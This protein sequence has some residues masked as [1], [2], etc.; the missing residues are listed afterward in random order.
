VTIG[1]WAA[2]AG[3]GMYAYLFG[4]LMEPVSEKIAAALEA[5]GQG[6]DSDERGV[7]TITK[8]CDAIERL[9]HM[10]RKAE[11]RVLSLERAVKRLTA[12]VAAGAKREREAHDDRLR[13]REQLAIAEQTIANLRAQLTPKGKRR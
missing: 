13:A 4:G 3:L 5:A 10:W 7:V 6:L 9:G 11:G 12:E 8:A 1:A 2:V